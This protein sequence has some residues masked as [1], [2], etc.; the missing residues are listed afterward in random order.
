MPTGYQRA[1]PGQPFQM[2]AK[3]YN[4]LIELVQHFFPDHPDAKPAKWLPD[5]S[6]IRV[7]NDSAGAISQFAILILVEPL[8]PPGAS[9]VSFSEDVAMSGRTPTTSYAGKFCVTLEP[10]NLGQIGLAVVAGVVPCRLTLDSSGA[11]HDFADV[12]PGSTTTLTNNSTS[13]AQVLWTEDSGATEVW[14]LVRLPGGA[15][16]GSPGP[17]GPAGPAAPFAT[18]RLLIQPQFPA[19]PP[20]SVAGGVISFTG[21]AL[22]GANQFTEYVSLGANDQV[23][24][25][26]D[27]EVPPAA[28]VNNG[29]KTYSVVGGNDTLTPVAGITYVPGFQ[30]NLGPEGRHNC[31]TQWTMDATAPSAW[32][33]TTVKKWV[34]TTGPRQVFFTPARTTGFWY[35]PGL[36]YDDDT[37]TLTPPKPCWVIDGNNGVL[38]QVSYYHAKRCYDLDPYGPTDTVDTNF[39]AVYGTNIFP[40]SLTNVA[41]YTDTLP[42]HTPTGTTPTGNTISLGVALGTIDAVTIQKGTLILYD[43]TQGGTN[44]SLP[45][46][47]DVGIYYVQDPTTGQLVRVD[48]PGL[49]NTK[50]QVGPGGVKYPYSLY[51]YGVP[52]TPY[53]PGTT[54]AKMANLIAA[55]GTGTTGAIG[56]VSA[57]G[58]DISG[59]RSAGGSYTGP[60]TGSPTGIWFGPGSS[61]VI[62]AKTIVAIPFHVGDA[63]TFVSLGFQLLN[64][65]VDAGVRMALALF[66]SSRAYLHP[67]NF[68]AG[69]VPIAVTGISVPA[70]LTGGF[71]TGSGSLKAGKYFLAAMMSDDL[72]L[73]SNGPQIAAY[74]AAYADLG[75]DA[76]GNQIFG[77]MDATTGTRTFPNGGN[78]TWPT[79]G[80]AITTPINPGVNAA[81]P[82]ILANM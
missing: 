45:T 63:Q 9:A 34:K 61:N 39:R 72:H 2:P 11:I 71:A 54:P 82:M 40:A 22:S 10:L 7:R 52:G 23:F 8:I 51:E 32:I 38:D 80:S 58:G 74:D 55:G 15:G 69:S 81:A 21:A 46:S 14:A 48:Y 30:I 75:V 33:R 47:T 19:F 66:A 60:M 62:P 57:G 27:Q 53:T 70:I 29:L 31:N 67:A 28:S 49:N 76:S 13:G 5:A 50:V 26:N 1:L 41:A 3:V 36:V 64:A 42:G 35:Y 59:S 78:P 37:G 6:T 24:W 25:W 4:Q 68:L 18:A 79:D 43:P 44:P 17:P 73:G 12:T 16:G 77:F 65:A 20:W 56:T